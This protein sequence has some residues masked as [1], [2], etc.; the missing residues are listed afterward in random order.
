[1]DEDKLD[2]S[3]YDFEK[4]TVITRGVKYVTTYFYEKDTDRLVMLALNYNDQTLY[5]PQDDITLDLEP[6]PYTIDELEEMKA[7]AIEDE[8]YEYAKELK[9]QIEKLENDI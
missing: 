2:F 5:I 1:M 6:E 9:E 7:A 3:Q 4:T 8:D